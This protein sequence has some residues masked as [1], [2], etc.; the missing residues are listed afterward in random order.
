[1]GKKRKNLESLMENG[2]KGRRREGRQEGVNRLTR[3]CRVS[4]AKMNFFRDFA[5][6]IG[7][8]E[9]EK[10]AVEERKLTGHVRFRQQGAWV[11]CSVR[12]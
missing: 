10:E 7:T 5:K 11:S 6:V 9:R 2:N 4:T 8:R 12:S 1:M 3:N